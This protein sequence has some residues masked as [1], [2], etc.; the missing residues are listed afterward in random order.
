METIIILCKDCSEL[1]H[2]SSAVAYH[3]CQPIF[4]FDKFQEN[5]I[6][7]SMKNAMVCDTS[8]VNEMLVS[9][10]REKVKNISRVFSL[11]EK[12]TLPAMELADFLG[13]KTIDR[14]AMILK[15]KDRLLNCALEYSPPS[16][17]FK[18]N[19]VPYSDIIALSEEW[20][21]VIFKLCYPSNKHNSF[22][23]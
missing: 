6:P 17:V 2:I 8:S 20:R 10:E 4:L 15:R 23:L 14:A 1:G 3:G 22:C 13:A 9:I 7:C 19:Q 18:L 5:N 12:G 11:H 21:H 16:I